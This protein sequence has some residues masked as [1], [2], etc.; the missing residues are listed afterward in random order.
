MSVVTSTGVGATAPADGS[1]VSETNVH[2]GVQTLEEAIPSGFLA[3][4]LRNV[5]DW[6]LAVKVSAIAIPVILEIADLVYFGCFSTPSLLNR[7]VWSV[8]AVAGPIFG[9]LEVT[10]LMNEV[11]DQIS[12]SNFWGEPQKAY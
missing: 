11:A 10:S 2:E 12:K 7:A 9:L 5:R 3:R 8:L 6:P 4:I 1:K